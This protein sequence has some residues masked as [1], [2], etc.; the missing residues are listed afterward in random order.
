MNSNNLDYDEEESGTTQIGMNVVKIVDFTQDRHEDSLG[1]GADEEDYAVDY[2]GHGTFVAGLI[3]SL[4]PECPGIAP[5]AEIYILKLFNDQEITYSA[6]FLDAFNFVLDND[7]DIVNLSTASKDTKDNPFLEKIEELT[8]A[9][10]I[11]VS[12][13]GND[14]PTQ[15]TA[16]SPGD[17]PTVIG[18]GSLSFDFSRVS[19]FSSRGMS[20]KSALVNIGVPKPDVLLPGEELEGLS[21][22]PGICRMHRG[23]SFSVPMLTGSIALVLSAIELE[24][25]TDFRKSVQNT[26]LVK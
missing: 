13:I 15:G 8:A 5:E 4:N 21:L 3:G 23:T 14:G 19:T 7:I 20:R 6:W 1:V 25:G 17:L 16:E 11:V 22:E 18:V 10:V 2:I 9:G 26:A 12:A 24:H